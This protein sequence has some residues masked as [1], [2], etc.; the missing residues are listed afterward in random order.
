MELSSFYNHSRFMQ[1]VYEGEELISAQAKKLAKMKPE[2]SDIRDGDPVISTGWCMSFKFVPVNS[3]FLYDGMVFKKLD[4]FFAAGED[5][6][7]LFGGNEE[8]L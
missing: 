7:Y 8:V 6:T 3:S 4:M 5:G 2:T 1:G